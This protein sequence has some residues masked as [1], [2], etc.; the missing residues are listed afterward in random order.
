MKKNILNT[1]F[2]AKQI[3]AK[4]STEAPDVNFA[5][6]I[7]NAI[8]L[9]PLVRKFSYVPILSRTF[10]RLSA[11]VMLFFMSLVVILVIFMPAPKG[12]AGESAIGMVMGSIIEGFVKFCGSIQI[13]VL[14]PL[15][16][17]ALFLLLFLDYLFGKKNNINYRV[18]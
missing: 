5:P 2:E 13:P 10:W 6:A 15:L 3:I 7:M 17:V 9:N 16:F 1:E 14:L 4:A 12:S 11:T 8:L 18:K